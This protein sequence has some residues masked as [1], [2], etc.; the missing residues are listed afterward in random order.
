MHFHW[1]HRELVKLVVNEPD[2][3]Q[4]QESARMLEYESGGMAI[5]PSSKGQEIIM[6]RGKN[7]QRPNE[8]RPRNLLNKQKAFK[9]SIEM[10]RRA[11]CTSIETFSLYRNLVL[12]IFSK[13]LIAAV[14]LI[15]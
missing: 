11:V 5:I 15:F 14:C 10:Q 4:L 3:V 1:K 7:Y 9:R 6:Y 2:P 8:L 12:S 13:K